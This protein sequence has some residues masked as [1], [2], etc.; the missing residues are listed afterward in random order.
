[1][2][3]TVYVRRPWVNFWQD[4]RYDRKQLD[5]QCK[6]IRNLVASMDLGIPG[7]KL[8]DSYF[9]RNEHRDPRTPLPSGRER[10]LEWVAEWKKTY[11]ELSQCVRDLKA[12]RKPE[13]FRAVQSKIT[14]LTGSNQPYLEQKQSNDF[15]VRQ[16]LEA[17]R[18]SAQIMLNARAVG[19]L[20]SAQ[21]RQRAFEM[22]EAA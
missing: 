20:A 16:T 13:G 9:K 10:Y 11:A 1:M 21:L 17:L 22:K 2:T 3:N 14:E 12:Q 8:Y 18:I 15:R 19:K 4:I 6:L 5:Q 7:F